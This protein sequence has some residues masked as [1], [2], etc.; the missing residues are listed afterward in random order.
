M[1]TLPRYEKT[2]RTLH[3]SLQWIYFLPIKFLQIIQ[4]IGFQSWY[5]VNLYAIAETGKPKHDA[6]CFASLLENYQHEQELA[7][8]TKGNVKCNGNEYK[9]L[10]E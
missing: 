7:R 10:A 8:N 1:D 3:W 2:L 5:Y 6:G 9:G 4:I